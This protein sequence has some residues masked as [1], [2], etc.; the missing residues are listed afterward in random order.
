MNHGLCK[1]L[2]WYGTKSRE[3]ERPIKF[4]CRCPIST[5][6][7]LTCVVHKW[8]YAKVGWIITDLERELR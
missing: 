1:E 4:R 8:R 3:C 2:I 7:K 5:A 6:E